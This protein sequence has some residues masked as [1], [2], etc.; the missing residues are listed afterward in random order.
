M[1][2]QSAVHIERDT[3]LEKRDFSSSSSASLPPPLGHN[4]ATLHKK[5]IVIFE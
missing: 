5:C 1:I 3:S 2:L 4:S